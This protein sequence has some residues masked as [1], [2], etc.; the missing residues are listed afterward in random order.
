MLETIQQCQ[1]EKTCIVIAP[2]GEKLQFHRPTRDLPESDSRHFHGSGYRTIA[3]T[4]EIICFFIDFSLHCAWNAGRNKEKTCETLISLFGR[5]IIQTHLDI[6]SSQCTWKGSVRTNYVFT[7]GEWNIV[8]WYRTTH[9]AQSA[10]IRVACFLFPP[11]KMHSHR[12]QANK[13]GDENKDM[14][15]KGTVNAGCD[16]DGDGG[17]QEEEEEKCFIHC[18]MWKDIMST[19]SART[20]SRAPILRER[21]PLFAEVLSPAPTTT[22][23]KAL[24][25]IHDKNLIEGTE[26][27]AELH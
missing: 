12:L 3:S 11:P 15:L 10:V 7:S 17:E 23:R 25:E 21:L 20:F 24:G 26:N 1:K 2:A 13:K 6:P 14:L 5:C 9:S 8:F 4:F 27:Y 18:T 22:L 16:S 19:Y